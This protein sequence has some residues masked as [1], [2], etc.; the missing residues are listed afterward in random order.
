MKLV[1][2]RTL[3]LE[4]FAAMD[5]SKN[6]FRQRLSLIGAR[7]GDRITIK[8]LCKSGQ[9]QTLASDSSTIVGEMVFHPDR[10]YWLRPSEKRR[11]LEL[12]KEKE[13]FT[14]VVA[15]ISSDGDPAFYPVYFSEKFPQGLDMAPTYDGVTVRQDRSAL[16]SPAERAKHKRLGFTHPSRRSRSKA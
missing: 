11:M 8:S 14:F 3:M 15:E 5:A 13:E 1:L 7:H 9:R 2:N 10:M 4:I 6:K 16:V 12:M